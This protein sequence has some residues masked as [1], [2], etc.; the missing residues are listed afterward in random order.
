MSEA[1]DR[2]ENNTQFEP[3]DLSDPQ[4]GKR[5]KGLRSQSAMPVFNDLPAMRAMK[6]LIDPP[7]I[8]AMKDLID[9]PAIRAMKDLIDP[10]AIRAMKDLIDPPT[11]CAMKDLIDPPAIRAMK[12]LID[13]PAIRAMKDLIDPPTIRAMKDLIDPPAIRAMKNL[14]DP[15]AMHAMQ[16]LIDSPALRAMRSFI[17]SPAMRSVRAL[18]NVPSMEVT[19]AFADVVRTGDNEHLGMRSLVSGSL[20]RLIGHSLGK[21][22]LLQSIASI[23]PS[24]MQMI[25]RLAA[26][27]NSSDM[28]VES[29]LRERQNDF[30]AQ[31]TPATIKA[32]IEQALTG[33]APIMPLSRDAFVVLRWI[34]TVLLMLYNAIAAW[35][36]FQTGL[37]DLQTR[38]I[39]ANSLAGI[40]HLVQQ[41]VCEIPHR[42][43]RNLR[44]TSD[45][46][47]RLYERPAIQS[48][49]LETLPRGVVLVV[50]NSSNRDWLFVHVT[51]DDIEREGWISR[52]F[53]RRFVQ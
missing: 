35:P 32:E 13:P 40:R 19:A 43:L 33:D 18:R 7:T 50:L 26:Q 22:M 46:G 3:G 11:I 48:T 39:S 5:S 10:P 37:C 2:P 45:E 42:T 14:I 12:N 49:M 25:A 16:A 41:N 24:R 21:S 30:H 9:P 28:S 47:I 27:Q 17:D 8:R 53:T 6:D 20:E 34:V 4:T 29:L 52:K 31:P 23:E 36:D 51:Y 44:Y 15:P 1:S 38:L